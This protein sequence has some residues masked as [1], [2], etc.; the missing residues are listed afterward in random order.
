MVLKIDTWGVAEL[1]WRCAYIARQIVDQERS[2]CT[3]FQC[4]P[5]NTSFACQKLL[6]GNSLHCELQV[7]Q[8]YGI[9]TQ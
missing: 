2:I 5:S 6:L 8:Q 9:Y 4:L 1:Q 7:C 3:P